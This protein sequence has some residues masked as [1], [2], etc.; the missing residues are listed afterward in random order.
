MLLKTDDRLVISEFWGF[1]LL[2]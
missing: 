1:L 2:L